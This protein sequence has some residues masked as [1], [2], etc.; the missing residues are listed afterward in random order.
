MK[1]QDLTILIK[2]LEKGIILVPPEYLDRGSW[3]V[4]IHEKG[5]LAP[6]EALHF[7]ARP[8]LEP[9]QRKD[10]IPK[11]YVVGKRQ[12]YGSTFKNS[13]TVSIINVENSAQLHVAENTANER[14]EELARA[15]IPELGSARDLPYLGE[16]VVQKKDDYQFKKGTLF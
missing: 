11:H 15:E 1:K 5:K 3:R 4:E 8:F 12:S 6:K 14:A 2:S 9:K 7:S 10:D 13:W 16:I